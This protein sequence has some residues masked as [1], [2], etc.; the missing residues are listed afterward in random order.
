ML[1]A[2]LSDVWG[3]LADVKLG[4]AGSVTHFPPSLLPFCWSL[5]GACNIRYKGEDQ[6][7]KGF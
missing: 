1:L 3:Q 7:G 5:T 2:E 6:P 4:S